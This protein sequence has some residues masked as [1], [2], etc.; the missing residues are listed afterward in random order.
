MPRSRLIALVRVAK[1]SAINIL[2]LF[3]EE[4]AGIAMK[5]SLAL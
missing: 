5:V 4:W 1:T 3:S 2:L